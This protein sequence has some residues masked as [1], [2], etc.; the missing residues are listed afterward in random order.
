MRIKIFVVGLLIVL[1]NS[2]FVFAAQELMLSK[3]QV[4]D[5]EASVE[6]DFFGNCDDL[7]YVDSGEDVANMSREFP[8]FYCQGMYTLTLDGPPGTTVTLFGNFSYRQ[9]RGYLVL[10]KKDAQKVWILE[11]EEFPGNQW[12]TV[13]AEPKS[14]AYEAYYY[15]AVNFRRNVSSVKWGQWW[16]GTVPGNAEV[17]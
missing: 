3:D 13:E 9:E 6:P 11:L 5:G 10:R 4:F 17:K 12:S 8:Y 15:P 16:S 7:F 1:I 2:T 14:G